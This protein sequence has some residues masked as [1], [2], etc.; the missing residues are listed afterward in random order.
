MVKCKDCQYRKENYIT[1]LQGQ[2]IFRFAY[3]DYLPHDCRLVEPDIRRRCKH[4][5]RSSRGQ[6]KHLVD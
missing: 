5:R 2:G 4:F 1:S 3:C 6:A